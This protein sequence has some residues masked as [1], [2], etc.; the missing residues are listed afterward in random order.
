MEKI[1]NRNDLERLLKI[2]RAVLYIYVDWSSYAAKTGLRVLEQAEQFFKSNPDH[3]VFFWL[4]DISDLNSP[5]AVIA[6]WLQ[7]QESE[8]KRMFPA[9]RT[10]NGSLVWLRKGQAIGV[11]L[12]ASHLGIDG[13][14]SKTKEILFGQIQA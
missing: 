14:I 12:S 11:A 4:A 7:Q 8:T 6:D 9:I 2:E 13:V 1:L 3:G 5:G 10:G